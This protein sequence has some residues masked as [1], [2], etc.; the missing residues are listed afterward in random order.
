M[1][2]R[3]FLLAFAAVLAFRCSDDNDVSPAE[4]EDDDEEPSVPSIPAGTDSVEW[5]LDVSKHVTL[6]PGEFNSYYLTA[7]MLPN[8]KLLVHSRI[9][10]DNRFL[11]ID[12]HTGTVETNVQ[13]MLDG[14]AVGSIWPR[15]DLPPLLTSANYYDLTIGTYNHEIHAADFVSSFSLDKVSEGGTLVNAFMKKHIY[16]VGG[17][18]QPGSWHINKLDLYGEIIWTKEIN[19]HDTWVN[20]NHLLAERDWDFVRAAQEDAI[21]FATSIEENGEPLE[22]LYKMSGGGEI[23]A[24]VKLPIT[25]REEQ[26][27]PLRI[28]Q[29]E[30]GEL[31]VLS[32]EVIRKLDSE[33]KEIW[34]ITVAG[35]GSSGAHAPDRLTMKDGG[36]LLIQDYSDVD[37]TLIKI[38]ASGR[39]TWRLVQRPN[40]S[41][42]KV[43]E[44]PDGGFI[45]ASRRGLVKKYA[46][47]K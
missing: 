44:L 8:D 18:L 26:N 17:N 6:P 28:D 33:G 13:S 23:V 43:L 39:E 38:D 9:E 34:K 27:W 29:N 2:F 40:T 37:V 14:N 47:N 15:R 5:T 35:L 30:Q 31:F 19:L 16:T 3:L 11:E 24:D 46:L 36:L 7:A 42:I 21:W 1:K 4:N 22:Q 41:I 45:T 12:W 10:G 32:D 25:S 20:L